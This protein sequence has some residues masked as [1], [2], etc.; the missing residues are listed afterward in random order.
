MAQSPSKARGRGAVSNATGRHERLIEEAFD[1]GWDGQEIAA[2]KTSTVFQAM[3]S[4]TIITRNN[5]PDIG[6]DSSINPYRGC[7]HG[8]I[9]CYAR[10]AHAYLGLSPGLDF[11][12]KIF[13][14][15]EAGRLLERALSRKTYR[16]EII[17][18]GGDTDPYQPAETR[19]RVTRS[20]IETL[21]RFRH[22][23]TLITKSNRILRDID[24]LGPL[25]KANLTRVAVSITTLDRRLARSMEPRAA[26]PAR[27]L[28]AVKALSEEGVPVTVMFAPVIPALNDHELESV[29]EAAAHAGATGAGYVLVRLPLEIATLFEEWLR[30]DHPDRA[31]RVMSHIRQTRGGKDYASEFGERMKGRGPIADL[32]SM[33]FAAARTRY[34][35][36][37]TRPPL[38]L[39]QFRVPTPTDG[40]LQLL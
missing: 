13:Y 16:P 33:R 39:S 7:E 19:L 31:R 28:E 6:F 21:G 11:E 38:D 4:K 34:G 25:G 9:Y 24:I 17:H 15:P 30:S 22:P 8:C 40:Q 2:S 5:S 27:R 10:P 36:L 35:L 32:I 20:I 14:K 37:G 18:I 12:S 29:L 26:T 3:K 1:D 23:F